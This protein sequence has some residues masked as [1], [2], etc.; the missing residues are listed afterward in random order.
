MPYY[1]VRI[2]KPG[3]MTET[4]HVD[5]PTARDA[6]LQAFP[7]HA[8]DSRYNIVYRFVSKDKPAR[9][10]DWK[11]RQLLDDEKGWKPCPAKPANPFSED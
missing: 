8:D 6:C 7:S 2:G 4:R 5:A 10:P 1:M 3:F 9:L 11:L